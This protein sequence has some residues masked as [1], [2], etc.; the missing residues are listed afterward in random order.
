MARSD[1]AD[2]TPGCALCGRRGL[3]LTRHHLVP[4]ARHRQGRTRRQHDRQARQE[5]IDLCRPCHANLHAHLSEKELA[6]TY[7]TLAALRAHPDIAR[8]TRWIRRKPAG[9]RV[10]VRRPRR[11]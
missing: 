7:H 3:A 6:D 11:L 9:L 4:R 2:G 5:T 8:F 10:P 1:S